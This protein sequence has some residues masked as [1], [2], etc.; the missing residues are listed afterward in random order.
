[1]SVVSPS[2]YEA[3]PP[4]FEPSG[5]V[6]DRNCACLVRACIKYTMRNLIADNPVVKSTLCRTILYMLRDIS[7]IVINIIIII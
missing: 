6:V 3:E 1:M 4:P 7:V 5:T 2:K